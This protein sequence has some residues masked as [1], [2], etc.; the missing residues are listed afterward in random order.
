MPKGT[1]SQMKA[2]HLR[3]QN[4][5]PS[6]HSGECAYKASLKPNKLLEYTKG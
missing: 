3:D 2:S 4:E 5:I 6:P 1:Q